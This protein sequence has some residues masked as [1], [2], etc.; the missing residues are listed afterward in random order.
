M[1]VSMIL[2]FASIA[3]ALPAVTAPAETRD[4]VVSDKS[5]ANE[6]SAQPLEDASIAPVLMARENFERVVPWPTTSVIGGGTSFQY[7]AEPLGN[8]QFKITFYHSAPF[9]TFTFKYTVYAGDGIV[10]SETLSAGTSSKSVQVSRIGES[11]RIVIQS[12]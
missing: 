11:F 1:K 2:G 9:S 6:R 3:A 8:D 4:V 10:A 7:K 12:I 5:L